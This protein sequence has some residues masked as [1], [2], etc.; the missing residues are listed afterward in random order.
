VKT[1]GVMGGGRSYDNVVG[2]RAVA[3]G[4][5][6]SLPTETFGI[7]DRPLRERSRRWAGERPKASMVKPS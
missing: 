2:L 5:I 7:K 6:A 4:M 1:V 3:V